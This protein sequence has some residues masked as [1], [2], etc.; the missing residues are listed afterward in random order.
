MAHRQPM[1]P[2][3][4]VEKSRLGFVVSQR[5]SKR[6]LATPAFA[7]WVLSWNI[8]LAAATLISR[9]SSALSPSGWTDSGVDGIAS[10]VGL[11]QVKPPCRCATEG[12][13]SAKN[14]HHW[15]FPGPVPAVAGF[16]GTGAF[17]AALFF[18]KHSPHSRIRSIRRR[19]PLHASHFKDPLHFRATSSSLRALHTSRDCAFTPCS[20]TVGPGN[21]CVLRT[22]TEV[23]TPLFESLNASSHLSS[24]SFRR[25]LA[26]AHV[27]EGLT[28]SSHSQHVTPLNEEISTGG[29]GGSKFTDEKYVPVYPL[30]NH[31]L[32]DEPVFAAMNQ[33]RHLIHK[34]ELSSK[35]DISPEDIDEQLLPLLCE[36]DLLERTLELARSNYRQQ[37]ASASSGDPAWVSTVLAERCSSEREA[38][39]GDGNEADISRSTADLRLD[40]RDAGTPSDTRSRVNGHEE[41]SENVSF[42]SAAKERDEVNTDRGNLDPLSRLRRLEH[43]SPQLIALAKY[44]RR[45]QAKRKAE[46]LL[47]AMLGGDAARIDALFLQMAEQRLLDAHLLNFIDEMIHE[48]H[49]KYSAYKA[50]EA[51][52]ETA[53]KTL[54]RRILAHLEMM[55]SNRQ[56]FVRILSLCFQTQTDKRRAILKASLYTVEDLERFQEWLEDGI[57]FGEETGKLKKEQL[58]VM[59]NLVEDCKQANPLN[60]ATL[61]HW[62]EENSFQSD[63]NLQAAWDKAD[64]SAGS[65]GNR[66]LP[67]E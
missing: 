32:F 52:S 65:P 64:E 24:Q 12:G 23:P 6:K 2:R 48:A 16:L 33:I 53:L 17:T 57:Q 45:R 43:L 31:V 30:R 41:S 51:L 55:K 62:Q 67:W 36:G 38:V 37:V 21:S 13:R 25:P 22:V 15:C 50:K 18:Q 49:M 9:A 46:R 39:G 34:L 29:G 58:T 60:K 56:D 40:Q 5:F 28:V 1:P 44:H 27:E 47:A 19:W 7:M 8:L 3:G 54:K 4:M 26:A 14:L 61:D 66:R 42:R 35:Q 10:R 63:L 11:S 20:F 59:R